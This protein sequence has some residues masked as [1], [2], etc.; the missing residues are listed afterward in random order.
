MLL[1][2][3]RHNYH[4]FHVRS[5]QCFRGGRK[6]NTMKLSYIY[7]SVAAIV[8]ALAMPHEAKAASCS[9]DTWDTNGRRENWTNVDNNWSTLSETS[10][11]GSMGIW[12]IVSSSSSTC[13]NPSTITPAAV[14]GTSMR[15][16]V[17]GIYGTNTSSSGD[18]IH[19]YISSAWSATAGVNGGSGAGGYFSSATG[20]GVQV[21]GG[22]W[23][24]A[25]WGTNG[26][27]GAANSTGTGVQ[28]VS[29]GGYGVYGS[30]S[31]TGVYGYGG[32]VGIYGQA[33]NVNALGVEAYATGTNSRGVWAS[34]SGTGCIAVLANGDLDY[35]GALVHVSDERLKRDITPLKG[36]T[37]KL[38]Q[39]Q[40]VSFYWKDPT[41]HGTAI[42]SN[43][44][45][46]FIAQDYEKV[47]PEWVSTDKDGMKMIDTTGLDS[48]EVESIREL[49]ADNDDLRARLSKLEGQRH[50]IGTNTMGWAV[51]GLAMAATFVVSRRKS[52]KVA[53]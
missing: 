17:P 3:N 29:Y 16:G 33:A 25:S 26:V 23:G 12:G 34:C 9:N 14:N 28:G 41:Q 18:G 42:S 38:L 49:K 45:R 39:L 46:G 7:A 32:S 36:A 24:V 4:T 51:A 30:S 19:G 53:K 10:G 40:G 11:N 48:L 37:E 5:E 8:V 44:Q 1:S 20:Y 21:Y 13:D 50:P 27:Y 52:N 6:K 2:I 47:F 31:S 35:T 15:D 43:I 22:P